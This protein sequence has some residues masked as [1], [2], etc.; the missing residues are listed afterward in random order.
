M[1]YH[2]PV[3]QA[4]AK[5][6]VL[7]HDIY[8]HV[9]YA[10]LALGMWLVGKRNRNGFLLRLVGEGIWIGIGIHL[11]YTSIVAWGI[12]DLYINGK[13]FLRWRDE[14]KFSQG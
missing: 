14:D 5:H 1:G 13:S 12:L 7:E 6:Q 4:A 2:L 8:G 11:G 9:G 3:H 10:M